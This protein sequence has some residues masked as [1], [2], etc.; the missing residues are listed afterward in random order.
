MA[1]TYTD[2]DFMDWADQVDWDLRFDASVTASAV[3]EKLQELGFEII[4][5]K[6][7]RY[8]VIYCGHAEFRTDSKEAAVKFLDAIASTGGTGYWIRD[9]EE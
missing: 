5:P 8:A 4:P 1:F 2:R 9:R 7:P 6:M 3:M